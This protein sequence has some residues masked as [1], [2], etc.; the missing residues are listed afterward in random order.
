VFG[1]FARKVSLGT[2]VSAAVACWPAPVFAQSAAAAGQEAPKAEE[3]QSVVVSGTR[4]RVANGNQAPTPVTTIGIAELQAQ[5]PKDLTDVISSVPSVAGSMTPVGRS[6]QASNGTSGISAPALRGLGSNRTLI[7]L[8]GQRSVAVTQTGETDLENIPQ[9]LVKRVDVVTGGASAAYGSDALAGVIN[10]VLDKNF[11][12]VKAEISGGQ[13]T[14]ND[15]RNW[16][17]SVSGGFKFADNRGHVLLSAEHA[18]NLGVFGNET[19]ARPPRNWQYD[20]P[21]VIANPAYVP[22][23][24][25]PQYIVVPHY[26][27]AAATKGGLIVNTALRGTAFDASGKPYQFNFGTLEKVAAGG[28][29]LYMSGGNQTDNNITGMEILDPRMHRDGL[30]GRVSFNVTDKATVYAQASLNQ[31]DTRGGHSTF[32]QQGDLTISADNAY[33]PASVAAQAKALGITSFRMGMYQP[34]ERQGG[35]VTRQVKRLVLGADASVDAFSTRWD[36][37][38]YFQTGQTDANEQITGVRIVSNYNQAIDAVIHPATGAIVCRSTLANPGNGCVPYNV[39]GWH[40]MPEAVYNYAFG[41]GH[42][43]R[44]QQ[45]RQDVLA[46]TVR[47]EPFSVPAGPVAVAAG[48]E[49]RKEAAS[50]SVDERSGPPTQWGTQILALNGSYT[51]NEAFGE[52][53]VPLLKDAAFAKSLDLNAAVRATDYSISGKVATYKVGTVWAPL[54]DLRLRLTRSRDIRAPNLAELFTQGLQITQPVLDPFRNGLQSSLSTVVTTGN[55][56]LEP[57]KAN[58]WAVGMVLAPRFLPGFSSSID[59][60]KIDVSGAIG[61]VSSQQIVDSCFAGLAQFCSAID[62]GASGTQVNGLYEITRVRNTF[63][64]FAKQLARGV[65]IETNYRFNNNWSVR[66][67]GTKFLENRLISGITPSIDLVGDMR[68]QATSPAIGAIP[69]WKASG[70]LTYETRPLTAT[71]AV[72]ALASG[73]VGG[74]PGNTTMYIQCTDACPLSTANNP[75]IDDNHVPGAVYFD[76]SFSYRPK[77]RIA[78]GE[79]EFF[80]GVRNIANR[81]PAIAPR[82]PGGLAYGSRPTNDWVYD[83][84]GRSFQG[85]V[86]FKWK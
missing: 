19:G 12:G 72:R 41:G 40:G 79:P 23:N 47:G 78:D 8:D 83:L 75:T 48:F 27:S 53:G 67:F 58:T 9:Q 52:L 42:P 66:V 64:N 71:L 51:V 15:D 26:G 30:F 1:E 31:N 61:T 16:K 4:L 68:A 20:S 73:F 55:L 84:I 76:A 3:L 62:R 49:H 39:F 57:E 77:G 21:G 54:D 35:L 2:A 63:F 25:K 60:Y 32:A 44:K 37:N 13:S 38:A 18:T 14:Y 45:F 50:G 6:I 36:L 33:L 29:P 24:G 81:D 59:Y 17:A 11:T 56:N 69:K 43:T 82:G 7:L 5:V 85:G 10:F 74:T 70:S 34:G 65:D 28:I 22:G 80:F 46:A 86:R